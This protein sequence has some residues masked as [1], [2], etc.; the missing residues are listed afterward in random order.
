MADH[1]QRLEVHKDAIR[2]SQA[3]P[4]EIGTELEYM[5][6]AAPAYVFGICWFAD[7]VSDVGT[8]MQGR[9][10]RMA[11][12]L[13]RGLGPLLVALTQTAS[14][15]SIFFCWRCQQE[16]WATSLIGGKLILTTEVWMFSVAVVLLVSDG[17]AFN[18]A[19]GAALF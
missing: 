9:R 15:F 13:A 11:D 12:G 18:Y 7:L 3:H 4:S 17:A 8:F 14:A 6:D 1:E 19:L 2:V 16:P 5:A 10:S